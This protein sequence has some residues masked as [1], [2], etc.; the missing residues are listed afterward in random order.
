MGHMQASVDTEEIQQW[1]S[2]V[3]DEQTYAIDVLRVREVLRPMEITPV[4]GSPHH[5]LGIINIRGNIVPVIDARR[6]LNMPTIGVTA[7]SRIILVEHHDQVI[8]VMVDRVGEVLQLSQSQ[9]EATPNVANTELSG[10]IQGLTTRS[11][12]LVEIID[13]ENLLAA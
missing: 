2:F 10:N 3:L 4:A 6:R 8:G 7:K 11:D 5:V 12:E 9:I 1:V 13:L